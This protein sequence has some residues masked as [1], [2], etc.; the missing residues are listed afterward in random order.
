MIRSRSI[1]ATSNSSPVAASHG[2]NLAARIAEVG[3]S[4]KLADVPGLFVPDTVDRAEKI[5]VC[6]RVRRLFEPPEVLAQARDRRGWVE[7]NFRPVQS[8]G[9]RSLREVPIVTKI[10]ANFADGGVE[11]GVT[12]IP[13]PEVKFFP[14][15]GMAMGQVVLAVFAQEPAVGVDDGGGVVIN[16]ALLRPRRRARSATMP[17]LPR[18]LAHQP[19]RR[20]VRHGL[21][22]ART[23]AS[24]A[25]RGNTARKII[26]AGRESGPLRAAAC[27]IRAR[28]FSIIACP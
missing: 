11:N 9:A 3:L 10:N 18:R 12:E 2:E 20:A 1:S 28:C 25:R 15:T 8:E 27:S 22:H 17:S 14:E 13:R 26:P 23:S 5:L 24:P 7:D 21:G 16:T 6:H 4:I 19:D